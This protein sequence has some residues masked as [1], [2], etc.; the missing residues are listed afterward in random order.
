MELRSSELGVN[1]T[2]VQSNLQQAE[3]MLEAV[4]AISP[5]AAGDGLGLDPPSGLAEVRLSY[6]A[7]ADAVGSVPPPKTLKGAVKSAIK[8]TTGKRPQ[9]LTDKLAERLAFER[10]GLR[11]YEALIVK[12]QAYCDEL[13]QIPLARIEE[14]RDE[15]ARHFSLLRQAIQDLGGDPTAQTPAADIAGVES[16]GLAQVLTDPRT[17]FAQSLHTIVVAELTDVEG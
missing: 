11:L 7:E 3:E 4:R 2:G 16:M 17:T 9:A 13:G 15:E 6:I 12:Y 10:S 8:M 5:T 14:I 1:R